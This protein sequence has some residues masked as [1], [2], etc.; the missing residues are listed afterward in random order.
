VYDFKENYSHVLQ[1]YH[2]TR[3]RVFGNYII[4][5]SIPLIS[6][7]FKTCLLER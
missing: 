4:R 1:E 5:W 7:D 2:Q 3:T 6:F